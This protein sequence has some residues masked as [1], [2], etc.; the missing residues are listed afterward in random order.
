MEVFSFIIN[1]DALILPI[2]SYYIHSYLI[3]KDSLYWIRETSQRCL[4]LLNFY[5]TIIQIYA[6]I[7]IL[8][9]GLANWVGVGMINRF[10]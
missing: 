4:I 5:K 10:Y 6:R 9:L 3:S 1:D 2:Q 7:I 8:I